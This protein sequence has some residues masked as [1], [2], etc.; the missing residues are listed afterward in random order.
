MATR[1]IRVTIEIQYDYDP[2]DKNAKFTHQAYL[3]ALAKDYT[4]RPI[5]YEGHNEGVKI[6]KVTEPDTDNEWW[7]GFN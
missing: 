5:P 2:E 1:T 6:T 3:D 4:I 7:I